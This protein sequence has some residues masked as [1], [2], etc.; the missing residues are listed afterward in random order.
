MEVERSIIG[1]DYDKPLRK[2]TTLVVGAGQIRIVVLNE[3]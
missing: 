3:S 2:P 1:R